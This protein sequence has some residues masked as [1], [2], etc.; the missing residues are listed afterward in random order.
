[1]TRSFKYSAG[2]AICALLALVDVVGL[3]GAGMDDA[4]PLLLIVMAAALGVVTLGALRPALH[5]SRAG[6]VTVIASR[7]L[8]VLLGLPVYFVTGAPAWAQMATTVSIAFT[9]LAVTLLTP[10]LRHRHVASAA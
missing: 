8:S 1:M 7:V 4:P 5:H 10:A 9:V 2:I 3:A 6:L